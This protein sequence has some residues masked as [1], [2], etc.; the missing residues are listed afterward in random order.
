MKVVFKDVDFASIGKSVNTEKCQYKIGNDGS[1]YK[2]KTKKNS[3]VSKKIIKGATNNGYYCIW[4]VSKGGKRTAVYNHIMVAQAFLDYDHADPSQCIIH[5]DR[6]KKNNNVDNLD[7][8][9]PERHKEHYIEHF[10]RM[11]GVSR[12]D[13]IPNSKLTPV[14]VKA[15]RKLFDNPKYNVVKIAKKYKV[16]VGQIYRIKRGENWSHIK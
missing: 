3:E 7:I 2:I 4:V 12:L 8:V 10:S 14:Q 6:N 1:V 11:K 5:K 13:N 16:T 15:I 9:C